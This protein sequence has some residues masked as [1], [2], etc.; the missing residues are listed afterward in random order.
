[1][2]YMSGVIAVDAVARTVV[3]GY[4]D[5]PAAACEPLKSLVT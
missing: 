2:L 4:D 1:M 3:T 5:L